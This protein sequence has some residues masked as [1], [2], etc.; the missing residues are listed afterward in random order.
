M[1]ISMWFIF[2]ITFIFFPAV[3]DA[4]NLTFMDKIN[5]NEASWFQ[6][7]ML[8]VFNISD[9]TGRYMGGLPKLTLGR[10]GIIIGSF[11]RVLFFATFLPIMFTNS[12][13]GAF[14]GSD[15]FKI[16]N[17]FAFGWTNGFFSTLCAIAAPGLVPANLRAET[18]ALTGCVISIGITTGA[19]LAIPMG[20]LKC[21]A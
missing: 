21:V 20:K 8:M 7:F 3:V 11:T 18:G 16:L 2:M 19:F 1:L 4:T 6:L 10:K 17:A 5:N 9:T 12:K 13:E 14:F 15:W